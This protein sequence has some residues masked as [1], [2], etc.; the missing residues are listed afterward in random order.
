[1]MLLSLAEYETT[2]GVALTG[3]QRDQLRRLAPSVTVV[4]TLGRD[5]AYDLTPSSSIGVIALAGGLQ[6]IIRPKLD[7]ERV[8]FLISYATGQ[9]RWTDDPVVLPE[10]ESVLEAIV[11]AFTSRLR[12]ALRRGVLQ[13]YRT[14]DAALVTVRGRWRIGDQIRTRFGLAPPVEV[15]YDDFTEDIEPNRI[16]RAALH[17]LLRLRFRQDR[18]R[19]ALGALDARLENVRLVDYDP[20]RVPVVAFDRRSEHYRGAVG[21]ARLVLAGLS[22][23]L[24]PG[25]VAGSSFLI[26]MNKVFEDF[27]VIAMRDA[28]GASD[29]VLVQGARGKSLFLDTGRQVALEPDLSLWSGARCLFVGDV[30]YKRIK[31]DAY[32]N[33]DLYQLTAYTIAT[34]LRAGMLI[35]AAGEEPAAGHEVVHIGKRLELVPLDLAVPPERLLAQVTALATRIRGAASDGATRSLSA[36]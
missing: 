17:R 16:L 27:V 2:V 14:E 32:P 10:A 3:E 13:G 8:M 33:A 5:D 34:G 31:P 1:M 7:I 30:K 18:L 25:V 36:A 11:P 22:F 28:L 24:G 35:Y 21:L 4:P 20:R 29:R 19:W 26:D 9:G 6:L 15:S 12:Q 23:D